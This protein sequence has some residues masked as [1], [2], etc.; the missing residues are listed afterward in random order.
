VN[1][2]DDDGETALEK[3][4]AGE[5]MGLVELLKKHGAKQTSMKPEVKKHT[6]TPAPGAQ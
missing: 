5:H 4:V 2:K 3:A 6:E 1:A